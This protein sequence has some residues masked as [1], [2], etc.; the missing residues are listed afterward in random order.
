MLFS[1]D[2]D[3][4]PV[5]LSGR[6][7]RLLSGPN[8]F[9]TVNAVRHIDQ[10]A[11]AVL[12]FTIIISTAYIYDPCALPRLPL[13][14]NNKLSEFQYLFSS[15]FATQI[16]KSARHKARMIKTKVIYRLEIS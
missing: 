11:S 15:F 14:S 2:K 1:L 12:I 16:Y 7:Q 5:V 8:L 6:N 3:N 4:K 13:K 10:F 9:L